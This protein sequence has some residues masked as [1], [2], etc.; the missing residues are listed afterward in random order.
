MAAVAQAGTAVTSV[1]GLYDV[2]NAAAALR[3]S[4]A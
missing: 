2:S 3:A 4:G 1:D